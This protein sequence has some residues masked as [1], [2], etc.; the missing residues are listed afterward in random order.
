MERY[1]KTEKTV[2]KGVKGAGEGAIVA[3]AVPLVVM[4][5]ERFGIEVD[6][7][8]ITGIVTGAAAL[9][10]LWVALANW[11]KHG[12]KPKPPKFGGVGY[13]IMLLVCAGL[14]MG[15][16]ARTMADFD[17]H[18]VTTAYNADGSVASVT[19]SSTAFR[20]ANWVTYGSELEEGAGNM[21][22]DWGSD[23]SGN[24]AVGNAATG[25]KAGEVDLAAL[26]AL[27]MQPGG[28]GGAGRP[29][30]LELVD[31]LLFYKGQAGGVLKPV[32]P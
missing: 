19:E 29:V 22:Y 23:G 30:W 32:E 31:M 27:L 16:C 10:G 2:A 28:A 12:D 18:Q 6:A 26:G 13:G 20:Q 14:L 21:Y 7:A 15:G 5:L 1:Y 25:A 11:W 8:V 9:Y 17:D 3:A 24:I 4:L